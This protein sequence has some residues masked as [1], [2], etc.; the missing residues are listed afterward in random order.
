MAEP[1]TCPTTPW[2]TKRMSLMTLIFLGFGL[3]FLYDGFIGYPKKNRIYDAHQRFKEIQAEKGAFL[4]KGNNLGQWKVV[5]EG[6]GYPEQ[7][8]WADYAHAKGWAEKPPKER[9][10]TGDQFFFGT[11]CVGIGL[12]VLGTMLVNRRSVMRADD[13][14]FY[15]PRGVRMPFESAFRIDKRKW[16]NKGLCYVSYR[17][18]NGRERRATI[19]DLKFAGADKILER[20]MENF[21]GELVERV[22]TEANQSGGE[23]GSNAIAAPADERESV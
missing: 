22:S 8:E 7:S 23:R 14:N 17:D 6:K 9:E 13:S 10:S 3:Y 20:L 1:I 21:E 5:A 4:A 19:D 12:A 16:G 2:Y 18:E 15:S 11:L